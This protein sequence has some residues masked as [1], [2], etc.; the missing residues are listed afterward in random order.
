MNAMNGSKGT[1]N[2]SRR[3]VAST[4]TAGLVGAM[5]VLA[6]SCGGDD[7]VEL[8]AAT[9]AKPPVVEA[10]TAPPTSTGPEVSVPDSVRVSL[11]P[12]LSLDE[13]IAMATHPTTG[14]VFL[15]SKLG[16]VAEVDIDAGTIGEP[17]VDIGDGLAADFNE[18]GLLGMAFSPDGDFMYLNFTDKDYATVV[19]EYPSPAG[20]VDATAGRTVLRVDQPAANHN[21]GH[22]TFGPDGL[23]YVSFGDGG[24]SGDE[25]GNGQDPETILGSIVRIDPE[26]RG[27]AAYAVPDTNPFATS[28]GAPEI[29]IWG[30]RNPWRFSFDRLTGDLWVADV[31]QDALEEVNVLY[32]A[33]GSAAGANLGWPDV[34][35]TA[36]FNGVGPQPDQHP[37]IYEYGRSDGCS[38]TGGYVYRGER[39]P[40]LWG[41]YIFGDYCTSELWGLASSRSQG[42]LERFDLGVGLIEKGLVSFFEDDAGELFILGF[43]NTVYRLDPA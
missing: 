13:P 15:A 7:G 29:Y 2:H 26:A 16:R 24:G 31:G 4:T 22:M 10:P 19:A 37:P 14:R 41:H 32:A 17:V 27:G 8:R 43:D 6:A 28:G 39:I 30:A 21:G 18:Q 23:L 25:F 33:D 38:V 9:D 1:P 36:P 20:V 40:E 35:G 3:S 5:I 42:V 34:E 12:V 11:T